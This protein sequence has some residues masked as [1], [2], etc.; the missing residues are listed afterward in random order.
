MHWHRLNDWSGCYCMGCFEMGFTKG[1]FL[2]SVQVSSMH[3]L[4]EVNNDGVKSKTT[5]KSKHHHH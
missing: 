2:S 1:L 5:N 4:S 3:I